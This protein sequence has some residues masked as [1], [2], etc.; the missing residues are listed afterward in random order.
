M[1]DTVLQV[2][3]AEKMARMEA[4]ATLAQEASMEEIQEMQSQALWEPRI[5][6]DLSGKDKDGN[7]APPPAAIDAETGKLYLIGNPLKTVR[8]SVCPKCHLPYQQ[9]D[10][11]GFLASDRDGKCCEKRPYV[12]T[13]GYDIYGR[14]LID[15]SSAKSRQR[16]RKNCSPRPATSSP[17]SHEIERQ[18]IQ[19]II[20]C[21]NPSCDRHVVVSRIA[22]HLEKCLMVG[23]RQSD[24]AAMKRSMAELDENSE[25]LTTHPSKLQKRTHQKSEDVIYTV[26]PISQKKLLKETVDKD[27][28]EKEVLLRVNEGEILREE[29][30]DREAVEEDG[31]EEVEE[32]DIRE[33]EGDAAIRRK[34]REVVHE[35]TSDKSPK[36]GENP[37]NE[38]SRESDQNSE[39]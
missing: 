34:R 2:H 26:K 18:P 25:K 30:S 5:L 20:Q 29:T 28:S 3:E 21:P 31:K 9:N 1:S 32:D 12:S 22:Q 6:Q 37:E 15:S 17:P 35:S 19:P 4:A 10:H 16:S 8:V 7:H 14:S 38:E 36:M 27:R 33:G 13:P 39:L 24:R 23:G 11:P